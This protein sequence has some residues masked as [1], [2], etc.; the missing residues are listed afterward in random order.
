[1]TTKVIPALEPFPAPSLWTYCYEGEEGSGKL[2][3]VYGT[4]A[5]SDVWMAQGDGMRMAQQ[6]LKLDGYVG[7][8]QFNVVEYRRLNMELPYRAP[9][10]H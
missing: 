8:F 6:Q 7:P 10:D 9:S 1:M 5:A 3:R 4:I 2:F